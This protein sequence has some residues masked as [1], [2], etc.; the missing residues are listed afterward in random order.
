VTANRPVWLVLPTYDEAANLEAIVAAARERLPA[1]RRVLIVDDNSPD[2]TGEIADRLA[3]E[4]EDVSVL[5]RES[6]Q[7]LGPA[8]VAGFRAALAGGAGLI[9]QM[10]ADFSHDPGDL[11][12]LL[13]A[14]ERAD[15]VLGSR[16]VVLTGGFKVFRREV[17]ERIG[18]EAIPSL[19]YAFQVETTYRAIRAGFRVVE[20]PIVFRDR[21]VGD[22]KMSGSIVAEAAFRIPMMRLARRP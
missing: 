4:H 20:V 17:L 18:L 9:A 11:P 16:Y 2:G 5:H 7:G 6:K 19:G 8:Y 10:D 22:S 14:T 21:R 12:R 3:A 1:E 13:A 15:L